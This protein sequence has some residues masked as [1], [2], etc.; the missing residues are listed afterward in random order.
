MSICGTFQQRDSLTFR[1]YDNMQR[2]GAKIEVLSH[3]GDSEVALKIQEVPTSQG[4]AHDF[5]VT[6]RKVEVHVIEI[7]F[8]GEPISQSPIRVVVENKNCE[9]V[10]GTD[11][12]REPD[13]NGNCVCAGN[14]YEMGGACLDSAYFF[15]IIF[16]VVYLVPG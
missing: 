8:D 5:T 1:I 15:L 11:S 6:N 4:F 9:A 2:V 16:A 10:Y 13:E 12:N 14:T 3:A 7:L